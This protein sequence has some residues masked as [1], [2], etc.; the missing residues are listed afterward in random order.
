MLPQ[1]RGGGGG[2][3]RARRGRQGGVVSLGV[4][5]NL[6]R[7]VYLLQSLVDGLQDGW[8]RLGVVRD[9]GTVH[10][11]E[12]LTLSSFFVP[13]HVLPTLTSSVIRGGHVGVTDQV[14]V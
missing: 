11:Y 9:G 6:L 4:Q 1:I 8:R 10:V 2:W 13:L 7:V 3:R 12:E 5:L 14:H